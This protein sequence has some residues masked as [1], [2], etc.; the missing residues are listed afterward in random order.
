[1]N[2][3]DEQSI[4]LSA[5]KTEGIGFTARGMTLETRI[6]LVELAQIEDVK[7][8]VILKHPL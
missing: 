2:K 7:N 6:Q 5:Y 8:Q 4:V 1:M 3:D